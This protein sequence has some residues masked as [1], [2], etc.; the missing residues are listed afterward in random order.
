MR[1]FNFH[2]CHSHTKFVFPSKIKSLFSIY[3][4]LFHLGTFSFT[5]TQRGSNADQ[6]QTQTNYRGI[7]FLGR[8]KVSLTNGAKNKWIISACFSGIKI[9]EAR[10][11][12]ISIFFFSAKFVWKF[13]KTTCPSPVATKRSTITYLL[14]HFVHLLFGCLLRKKRTYTQCDVPRQQQANK[15]E[16]QRKSQKQK[17]RKEIQM[18]SSNFV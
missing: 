6:K 8:W 14:I 15:W 3:P 11:I 17:N 2:L 4:N 13:I 10:K 12:N 5:F 18:V 16:K 1:I 7:P 9:E